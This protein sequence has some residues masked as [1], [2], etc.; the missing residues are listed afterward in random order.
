[1]KY[2]KTIIKGKTKTRINV[3]LDDQCKNGHEDFAITA[4][5]WEMDSRNCWRES[6]GGCCHEHIL[7]IAP[8]F[9]PFIDL[10]LSTYEGIPMHA[11]S[12]AFYWFCG[13]FA[14]GLGSQYHGGSGRDGKSELECRRIFA[15]LIRA[16]EEQVGAL[17]ALCPR[18]Q[19]EMQYALESLD[20]PS[21]WKAQADEATALLESWTG[22]NF[23]SQ[24]TRK[25]WEPLAPEVVALI[26]ERKASGYYL[27]EQVAARDAE[28]RANEKAA[29]IAAIEAD[30]SKSVEKL[31]KKKQVALYFVKHGH[32]ENFI[33][34]DHTNEIHFNWT[35]GSKLWTREEFEQFKGGAIMDE[36]PENVTFTFQD[37][38][39]Y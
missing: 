5:V 13:M 19:Q 31:A 1:M 14:D 8:E 26:E 22:E 36:L 29:K 38:P 37:K 17:M 35:S 11:A 4:D 2:Q 24:A 7:S 25:T 9:K 27:P 10:H 34:Y 30:F 20:F 32:G 16:S 23:T 6:M 21:Q 3:R 15:D 18:N 12:N 28:K 39:K 33:F